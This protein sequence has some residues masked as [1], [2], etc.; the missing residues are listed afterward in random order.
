[1]KRVLIWT[2]VSTVGVL[3][4][5]FFLACSGMNAVKVGV[6]V[7][8]TG[9]F[10]KGGTDVLHGV[11]L[12]VD[13]WNNKG[14][15]LGK[16]I[17]LIQVDDRGQADYA[18]QAAEELANKGAHI[19]IG[20]FNSDCSV[21][22]MNTYIRRHVLMISPTSTTPVLTESGYK[23]IFRTIG[24]DDKQGE[25]AAEYVAESLPEAKVAVVH[26]GSTYGKELA[27]AFLNHY[28][29]ITHM[30]PVYY[31]YMTPS[32]TNREEILEKL[33][34]SEADLLYFGGAYPTAGPFLKALRDAGLEMTLMTGDG[35]YE[36]SFIEL[37]GPE[38][39]EGTLV[40]FVPDPNVVPEAQPIVERYRAKFGEPGPY[41]LFA[42]EAANIVFQG[43]EKAQS[44]EDV[45]VAEA[46]REM[47]FATPF[48]T[49]KFDEKGDINLAPYR[50]WVIEDGQFV[51]A[52]ESAAAPAGPGGGT[53][54]E[55]AE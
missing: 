35:N 43:I 30:E 10:A 31:G 41:S 14:G 53:P 32:G 46:L 44:S 24:R 52:P 12:A 6:A 3:A 48:G 22:A 54:E 37:A 49:L 26:D 47:S 11:Q 7:P 8:Q 28:G 51:P 27:T 5:G 45:K 25:V 21:A 15:V 18:P 29:H 40:T 20:H 42:Y 34:S 36:P 50:V 4:L 17:E 9:E 13:D 55:P 19:V 2:A 33:E 1:M 23:T 39:A 16:Q 38:N